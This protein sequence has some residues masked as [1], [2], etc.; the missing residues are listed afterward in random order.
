MTGN[1]QQAGSRQAGR[2][3]AMQLAHRIIRCASFDSI[4]YR[5]KDLELQK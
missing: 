5:G 2:Q 3:V 1:R 4:G